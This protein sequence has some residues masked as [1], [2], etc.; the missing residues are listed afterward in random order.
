MAMPTKHTIKNIL[1]TTWWILLGVGCT[2]LLAAAVGNK[3][4]QRC[5]RVDVHIHGA[6]N[7]FFID[8]PDVMQVVAD[9]AGQNPV[10]LPMGDFDLV[11][12]EAQLEKDVWVKNAEVYFDNHQVLQVV[13][14]EREPIA[15]V[16]TNGTRSFYIDDS[17]AMLP[18]SDKFSARV[19]V[20][21]G[22]PSEAL[23]LSKADSNLLKEIKTVSRAME[24]DSFLNIL[25]QQ[26]AINP[27]R[28]FEL[29]PA[30]GNQVILL[31]DASNLEAKI[32]KLKLFYEQV[33]A[34]YGWNRYSLVNLQ[35][36][37]QIV[38][39][40]K[41]ADD[42]SADSLRTIQLMQ[43][44]ALTAEKLASDSIQ[45]ILQDNERNTADSTMIIQVI[46]REEEA[47]P[48]LFFDEPD[49]PA[50][51]KPQPVTAAPVHSQPARVPAARLPAKPA[52][53]AAHPGSKPAP[54][55]TP[56]QRPK[57]QMPKRN[58]H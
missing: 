34:K 2:V 58:N 5:K 1:L 52:V 20:F 15:R 46:P 33:I 45:T 41:G 8:Q 54:S 12:M 53:R 21:T 19:P 32:R 39:K 3:N 6:H 7:H 13:V 48:S 18:L 31:G 23:V 16:F 4:H 51:A 42:V 38:A 14:D 44:M 29:V 37:G 55:S 40:L 56:K 24:R 17:P 11:G 9:Y 50:P 26:V 25:I 28:H 10:G 36:N 27:Q 43:H 47:A 49:E 30:I 57:V 35:Y 22:F